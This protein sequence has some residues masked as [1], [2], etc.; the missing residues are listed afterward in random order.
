MKV[1]WRCFASINIAEKKVLV[2]SL[3]VK[4]RSLSSLYIAHTLTGFAPNLA[5]IWGG[6]GEVLMPPWFHR[7]CSVGVGMHD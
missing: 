1:F 7:P 3:Y 6:G 4:R 2:Q 5:K